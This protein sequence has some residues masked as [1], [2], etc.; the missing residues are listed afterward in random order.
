MAVTRLTDGRATRLTNLLLA[1]RRR[2]NHERDRPTSDGNRFFVESLEH[3]HLLAGVTIITQGFEPNWQTQAPAWLGT[4]SEAIADRVDAN[5][6]SDG[7]PRPAQFVMRIEDPLGPQGPHVS[8]WNFANGFKPPQGVDQYSSAVLRFAEDSE[9]IVALDW[10]QCAGV[11]EAS[12]ATV[13]RVA[14]DYFVNSMGTLGPALLSLPIHLVGHSRGGSL[15]SEMARLFGQRGLVIDQLTT[16]DPHPIVGDSHSPDDPGVGDA[17]QYTIPVFDNVIFSD[18]YYEENDNSALDPAGH[19]VRG[20]RNTDLTGIVGNHTQIAHSDVHTYYYGTIQLDAVSDGD[21]G[22]ID[23]SWY[24]AAGLQRTTTGFYWTRLG[25]GAQSTLGLNP[26]VDGKGHRYHVDVATLKPYSNIEYVSLSGGDDENSFH[27]T[28]RATF[29]YRYQDIDGGSTVQLFLDDD[30]NPYN[31]SVLSLTSDITPFSGPTPNMPLRS[32]E[33]NWP[34]SELASGT[35][36]LYAQITNG[37]ALTRYAYAPLG[38]RYLAPPPADYTPPKATL[39]FPTPEGTVTA[40]YL[41]SSPKYIRI[42]FSDLGAGVDLTSITD[43]PAEFSLSGSGVGTAS[44]ASGPPQ[45]IRGTTYKYPFTGEFVPGTV[46]LT[47]PSGAFA[48]LASP[49]NVNVETTQSFTVT[50]TPVQTGGVRATISPQEAIDAGARWSVDGGT[51]QDS[52]ATFLDLTVG[53]HRVEF[54]AINGWDTPAAQTIDVVAGQTAS[55]IG[56]YARQG[57]PSTSTIDLIVNGSFESGSAG[58]TFGGTTGVYANHATVD[59]ASY[60]LLGEGPNLVDTMFQEFNV[61]ADATAAMLSYWYNVTSE[62]TASGAFDNLY[63]RLQNFANGTAALVDQR[64]NLDKRATPT[65]YRK[66]TFDLMPYRG[67]TLRLA[68]YGNTDATKN[69]SFRI[70]DVRA[71]VTRPTPSTLQS[72]SISGPAEV[73]ENTY[74]AYG[75]TAYFSDGSARLVT[76]DWKEDSSFAGFRDGELITGLVSTDTTLTL[77]ATYTLNGVTKSATKLITIKDAPPSFDSLVVDGPD[78]ID[79][80]GAGQYAAMAAFNDGSSQTVAADWSED[81]PAA[82][83]S[84]TGLLSADPVEADTTI[85]VLA[86]FSVDGITR[87]A[88]KDVTIRN[89]NGSDTTPPVAAIESAPSVTASGESSYEFRIQYADNIGVDRLTIGNGDVVV[90][91]PNGYSQPALLVSLGTSDDPKT[92]I[93]TYRVPAPSGLWDEVDNGTYTV[94]MQANQVGD[95][96]VP[97]NFVVEGDLGTFAVQI[98]AT[99]TLDPTFGG[100]SGKVVYDAGGSE[101]NA[102]DVVVLPDGRILVPTW[103]P[104]NGGDFA[105]LRF[106][107]DGSLDTTFGNNGKGLADFSGSDFAGHIAIDG[108]GRIIMVGSTR[109]GSNYD[110]AVA[111]FNADGSLDGDFSN[112]GKVI[113]DFGGSGESASAVAVL[114]DGGLLVVGETTIGPGGRDFAIARYKADGSPDSAFSGGD[115][116][117]TTDFGDSIDSARDVALLPGGSFLVAGA[118][119]NDFAI[120]QYTAAGELDLNFGGGAGLTTIDFGGVDTGSKVFILPSGKILLVGT[121]D[122]SLALARLNGDGTPDTDFGGGDGRVKIDPPTPLGASDIDAVMQPDGKVLAAGTSN[123]DF[124]LARCNADGTLDMSFHGG[125]IG[126]DING[127]LDIAHAIALQ[128][129]G[130][131]IVA[132]ETGTA[133]NSARDIALVRYSEDSSASL[134]HMTDMYA[135]GSRWTPTFRNFLATQSGQGST[136][137]FKVSGFGPD[138]QILSFADLDTIAV[139]FSGSVPAGLVSDSV[140]ITSASGNSYLVE[141]VAPDPMDPTLAIIKLFGVISNDCVVVSFVGAA[142]ADGLPAQVWLNVLPADVNQSGGAINATDLVLTRNRIGRTAVDPGTGVSGYTVFNDFNGDG[143]I[144]ATDLVLVRNRIGRALPQVPGFTYWT[145]ADIAGLDLGGDAAQAGNVLR[146][147]PASQR[148]FGN[149]WRHDAVPVGEGFNTTFAFRYANVGGIHDAAGNPG[150]DGFVFAIRPD[151]AGGRANV[152]AAGL[153]IW[154]DAYKN[155]LAEAPD[156]VSSSRVAVYANGQRLGQIDID[157]LGIRFREGGTHQ[158][159]AEYDGAKLDLWLDGRQLGTFGN[160]SLPASAFMGFSGAAYEAYADQELLNWSFRPRSAVFSS[161]RIGQGDES[162]D[163]EDCLDI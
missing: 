153:Y 80:D 63:V 144:N 118:A 82:T 77:S 145:F 39:S 101:D 122:G 142:T 156:D 53:S 43:A 67:Q 72:L 9:A 85:H 89:V 103:I 16:L 42:V 86:S 132:G 20:A 90:S 35:Y 66:I 22:T 57:Q 134:P 3:R 108:N 124:T 47:F 49:T 79:E 126:T 92:A 27:P 159:T 71:V 104:S 146:V 70:D 149:V 8:S 98:S 93:A 121:S 4:M 32:I 137:G 64:S 78:E 65:E 1:P 162:R 102:S 161:L 52:G 14:V 143:L 61:P 24:S 48:D 6:S 5:H 75:A 81:S 26:S 119:G 130:R 157:A 73:K 91:G 13:A 139:R 155:P 120:A 33:F 30:R 135:A 15:V 60:A 83:I 45:L 10:T 2:Q 115:G 84:S 94:R 17:N 51:F 111:R 25:K 18:N 41:N 160:I 68:F 56:A 158:F 21:G 106:N 44:I 123:G 152:G 105:L 58:W 96:A 133:S 117:L 36:S 113:S 95:T 76:P 114:A 29:S 50:S 37:D 23:D 128:A 100:G 109:N 125:W 99:S 110:F 151:S 87:T 11:G 55:A 163:E 140:T 138:S 129:N 62:E 154:L 34:M 59:G 74:T 131:I 148:K 46:T 31:G 141:S 38:V 19:Y 12:T 97:T 28:D 150:T 136:A 116:L 127:S 112:G 147:N 40:S 107:S 7:A 69:T 88:S 54:Q